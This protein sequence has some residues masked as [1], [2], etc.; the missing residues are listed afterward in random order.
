MKKL[1]D[2]SNIIVTTDNTEN[3]S[4]KENNQRLRKSFAK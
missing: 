2:K 3:A 4:T 1:N